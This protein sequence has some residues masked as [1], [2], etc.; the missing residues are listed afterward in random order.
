MNVYSL[1]NF[2]KLI[3][4]TSDND[5]KNFGVFGIDNDNRI[6]K[7]FDFCVKE[8]TFKQAKM[9]FTYSNVQFTPYNV[10]DN[11]YINNEKVDL[12]I[13]FNKTSNIFKVVSLDSFSL[14]QKIEYDIEFIAAPM[15]LFLPTKQQYVL[16][17]Q[18]NS[19]PDKIQFFEFK[20]NK[21]EPSSS[22]PIIENKKLIPKHSSA[23]V[24]LYGNLKPV[25]ALE[26]QTDNTVTLDIYDLNINAKDPK[27]TYIQSIA[28]DN[29]IGPIKFVQNIEF[30][31]KWDLFYIKKSDT[32]LALIQLENQIT[33]I[34][35]LKTINSTRSA[36]EYIN[37]HRIY[38]TTYSEKNMFQSKEIFQFEDTTVLK[39]EENDIVPFHVADLQSTGNINFF[40]ITKES[41][42]YILNFNKTS[43]KW[44]KTENLL[45][46]NTLKLTG[47]SQVTSA[48]IGNTGKQS[49][50]VLSNEL[51]EITSSLHTL[52]NIDVMVAQN[53]N[54]V[55][56]VAFYKSRTNHS[57]YVP[58][59]SYL[60]GFNNGKEVLLASQSMQTAYPTLE[61]KGTFIGVGATHFFL[62][63]VF[64]SLPF[65]NRDSFINNCIASIFPTTFTEFTYNHAGLLSYKCFFVSP[66][67]RKVT[68]FLVGTAIMTYLLIGY[69]SFLEK[70]KFKI[71]MENDNIQRLMKVI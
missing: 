42:L 17:S 27:F 8:K 29:I 36:K 69:L 10:F 16:L 58:G 53:N 2:S 18:I 22:L 59:A 64:V 24:D 34:E 30:K 52:V 55:E 61:Q 56:F 28:L 7:T 45:E 71:Q 32:K 66:H 12:V 33:P 40:F 60:L 46:L 50:I 47:I 48:D 4:F 65:T 43:N 1:E 5:Q 51:K 9:C 31:F 39:I 11:I 23:L 44:E 20:N 37:K 3:A 21:L 41:K 62:T 14:E 63:F 68:I 19:D 38:P 49:L 13:L 25:L 70:R 6:C 35:K 57:M 54:K 67:L 15:L 26:I